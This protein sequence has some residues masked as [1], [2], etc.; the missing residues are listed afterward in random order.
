MSQIE[1]VGK[2]DAAQISSNLG[3]YLVFD[4]RGD[5]DREYDVFK[6]C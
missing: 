6:D 4:D 2:V 3:R 1:R 5:L